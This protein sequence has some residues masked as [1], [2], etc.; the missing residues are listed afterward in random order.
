MRGGWDL[1]PYFKWDDLAQEVL[2]PRLQQGHRA[3]GLSTWPTLKLTLLT[4]SY[5]Q[6]ALSQ[7][8]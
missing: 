1:A 3:N 8:F 2:T 6:A 7:G 4:L 5:F